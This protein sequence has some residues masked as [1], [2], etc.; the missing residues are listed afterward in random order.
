MKKIVSLEKSRRAAEAI[1]LRRRVD[2]LIPPPEMMVGVANLAASLEARREIVATMGDYAERIGVSK[3]TVK[4]WVGEGMPATKYG[5]HASRV[6]VLAA[7]EWLR[8]KR[9]HVIVRK[10]SSSSKLITIVEYAAKLGVPTATVK[11]WVHSDGMPTGIVFDLVPG[12]HG[13]RRLRGIDPRIA[14]AWVKRHKELSVA[15]SR[16]AVLFAVQRT[17]GAVMLG[18]TSNLT[19][20]TRELQKPGAGGCVLLA[21]GATGPATERAI[22]RNAIL[23]ELAPWA[24]GG[25]WFSV[26]VVEKVV[27]KVGGNEPCKRRIG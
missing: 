20:R 15:F 24:L 23:R 2:R 22:E 11:R 25:G 27:E 12:Q 26:G 5:A 9:S 4:R 10:T 18:M 3:S 6:R 8:A 13:K 14:D 17:D 21:A 19:R 7:D 16:E 1:E